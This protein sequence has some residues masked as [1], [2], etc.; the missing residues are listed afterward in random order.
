V[1]RAKTVRFVLV[2]LAVLGVQLGCAAILRAQA[3]VPPQGEGTVSLTYQNYDVSGH[4]DR[5]GRKNTNGGTRSEAL[6][7]DLDYGV[8]DRIG[9]S[10]SLPFIASKYTGPPSYFVGPFETFPGRL[11]DGSYHAAFQDLRVEARRM[12]LMGPL[13]VTP[14]IGGLFPTHE[15]ETVGEAVPG[16]HRR[17]LQLGASASARLDPFLGDGSVHVRYMYAA[18]ERVDNFPYTRSNIDF[19]GDHAL[20]SRVALR[21]LVRLQIAHKGP[22]LEELEQDWVNH[23][24]FI[25]PNYLDLGGGASASLTHSADVYA[26]WVTTVSGSNGAHRAQTLAVGASWSFGGGI[27]GLGASAS[28]SQ[29]SHSM[30]RSPRPRSAPWASILDVSDSR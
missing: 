10:L 4:F 20:T 19:E 25:A 9:L 15:Y 8:T 26:L 5:Q 18:A 22:T 14:F 29:R 27:G 21:G 2:S 13:A 3:W 7:T 12:F 30:P 17:E 23:D 24:R 16:R 11:D 6:I 28:P 1:E